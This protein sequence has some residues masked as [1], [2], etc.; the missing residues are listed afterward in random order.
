MKPLVL[1]VAV[2][3]GMLGTALADHHLQKRALQEARCMPASMRE[4]SRS[5][6]NV[7]YSVVCDDAA[8]REITL[9]CT[10]TRCVADAH[11][12][13]SGADEP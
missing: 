13:H 2:V 6:G 4:A 7:A 5:G 3:A 8:S 12:E 9:V 1:A 10:P 11:S